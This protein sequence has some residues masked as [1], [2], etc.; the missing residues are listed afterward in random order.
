MNEFVPDPLVTTLRG[1]YQSDQNARHLFDHFSR[2]QNKAT[3]TSAENVETATGAFRGDAVDLLK[4]LA[5]MGLGT[6]Y[7]GRRGSP[8]RIEWDYDIRE[9]AKAA[10]GG[11]RSLTPE[12]VRV[13]NGEEYSP[14]VDEPDQTLKQGAI[15]HVYQLRAD[16]QIVVELP[17]DLTER[18]A[19]RIGKWVGSLPFGN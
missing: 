17:S 18:E 7:I 9:I 5:D 16:F 19:D 4:R 11:V 1:L 2:R 13:V 3:Q 6:Y 10:Q 8:T 15:R 14:E 12:I